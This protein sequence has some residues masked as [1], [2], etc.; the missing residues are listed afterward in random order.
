MTF[1]IGS[2]TLRLAQQAYRAWIITVPH[3]AKPEAL[4]TPT[5]W[6]HHAGQLRPLD[7]IRAVWEDGSQEVWLTVIKP[8]PG[9]VYVS[10]LFSATHAD[11]VT[12]DADDLRIEWKGPILQFCIMRKGDG[13]PVKKNLYPKDVAE[14]ELLRMKPQAA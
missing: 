6:K 3:N 10:K 9:A 13:D 14:A 4:L 11:A 5:A 2:N 8:T 1:T 12:E 7:V